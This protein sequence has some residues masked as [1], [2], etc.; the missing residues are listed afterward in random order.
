[1][2]DC[3]CDKWILQIV[4]I[5]ITWHYINVYSKQM[6]IVAKPQMRY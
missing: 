6:L 3:Y 4:S 5:V 2:L 1:M